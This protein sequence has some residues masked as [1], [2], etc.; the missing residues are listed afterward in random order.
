MSLADSGDVVLVAVAR[1]TE[2]GVDVEACRTGIEE[3]ALPAH[4]LTEGER[5]RL[6]AVPIPERSEAFLSIWTRKEALL[7]AVGTGLA[8]DPRLIELDASKGRCSTPEL[9]AGHS[10]TLVDVPLPGYAAALALRGPL[11]KLLL[12]DA[13]E[14]APGPTQSAP[15]P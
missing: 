5:A 14:G 7:K 11:T 15:F 10:W 9:G 6:E 1:G 3:W 8:V 2:I 4:A 13:R 12:Y